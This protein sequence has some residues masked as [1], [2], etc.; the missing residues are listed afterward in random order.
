MQ[1][2]GAEGKVTEELFDLDADP[3]E[4]NNVLEDQPD[5]AARLRELASDYLASDSSPWGVETPSVEIDEMELNQL[6]ALGY[7]L[8]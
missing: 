5:A 1:T 6:R 2:H 4:L 3:S 8:P 7:A